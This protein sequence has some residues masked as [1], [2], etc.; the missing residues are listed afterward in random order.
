MNKKKP[1]YRTLE[2]SYK[3]EEG[4]IKNLGGK[5]NFQDALPNL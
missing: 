5:H 1:A 2:I 3:D 4:T